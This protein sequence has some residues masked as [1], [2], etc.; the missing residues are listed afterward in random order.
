MIKISIVT[1]VVFSNIYCT[2]TYH[3]LQCEECLGV[4]CDEGRCLFSQ[5]Y[6]EGSSWDAIQ[7]KDQFYCGGLD[8]LDAVEPKN[9]KYAINFMFGC[10][11]KVNGLFL[12]Q[13]ADGIMGMSA[14]EAT[15]TKQLWNWGTLEHNMFA[16]CFRR[17]LGT[18]KR[19]VPAGSM[20]LGGA[21]TNLDSSPVVYAKNMAKSG[22]FTVYVKNIFVRAGGGQSAKSTPGTRT[23]RV[24]VDLA[25][26]NSGKGVIVD[27]GT[28]DTYLNK[29]VGPAFRRAWKMATGKPYSHFPTVLT[30]EEL[31]RLPTILVQCHAYAA[32][33][34]AVE[35]YDSIPGYVGS[36]DPT[37]PNDLLIAIPAT[38][39]MDYSPI[40]KMYTSRL[41]LTE[42]QGGVLGSNTMQGH[43]VVF[44]WRLGRIGFSESSCTYDKD[45]LP[46]DLADD[47]GYPADCV[48]HE[49][50]LTTPCSETVEKSICDLHPTNVALLGVERWT[51]LVESPGSSAGLQCK[52]VAGGS[53]G[54][55]EGDK[56]KVECLG[57]GV[58]EEERPCQ[59]TCSELE[60]VSKVFATPMDN[61][62]LGCGD[63][64]W[65]ACDSSC[66]QTRI[67]SMAYSDGLCH[68]E[69]RQTRECNMG[70]CM[71]DSPCRI[72]YLLH[73]VL[74]FS[75]LRIRDWTYTADDIVSQ[76][77]VR[78]AA[79]ILGEKV[80]EEGDVNVVF[81]LP[82]YL[83]E[84]NPE[85]ALQY[86]STK[87]H[88]AGVKVV[89]DISIV[90]R[91]YNKTSV[92]LV[93]DEDP[94]TFENLFPNWTV[95]NGQIIRCSEKDLHSLAKTA[96]HLKKN[97]LNAPNFM[98]MLLRKMKL[99]EAENRRRSAYFE[100][101]YSNN[102]EKSSSR[103]IAAWSVPT[104]VDED[105]NY[106]GPHRPVW[107]ILV[108]FLHIGT[109]VL[110]I[111]MLLWSV[112][113][114]W[115]SVPMRDICLRL[116]FRWRRQRYSPVST[117]DREDEIENPDDN[118]AMMLE[119]AVHS[120]DRY[121][122]GPVFKRKGSQQSRNTAHT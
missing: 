49:P 71:R 81:S 63:S 37:S 33:D 35:D 73:A 107:Y 100:P 87:I 59:L 91:S 79:Q 82:W 101:M 50:I 62:R 85:S 31:S 114:V 52:E 9:R 61:D 108:R 90:N 121:R 105:I 57:D 16:L 69:E 38:S 112:G 109:I 115:L 64:Y 30:D 2:E 32:A 48:V 19:G 119:L 97:V 102:T 12:T 54:E 55:A 74:G 10:M 36:L 94:G 43:N 56:R 103:L 65:S 6:T 60:R 96:L 14:H 34:P 46:A 83:D 25:S 41:Y 23:V 122:N 116:R 47:E 21:S 72:P 78:T 99:I 29:A 66:R 20:T 15:L 111:A 17:E 42:S 51:A 93:E 58:C 67:H 7:V 8:V 3:Q 27:S 4:M 45:D 76:A 28:T 40:T 98:P 89:I 95:H 80:F 120:P 5:S 24:G 13:L 26:L 118:G 11:T 84:D 75:G 53:V 113:G 110:M 117:V 70:V 1:T 18:S 88:S 39:Y 22:W 106:F 44:D 68:E 92:E 104:G 77:L 86:K